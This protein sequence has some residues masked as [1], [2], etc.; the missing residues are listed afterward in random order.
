MLVQAC[1][2]TPH[3]A[4]LGQLLVGIAYSATC[5]AYCSSVLLRRRDL[6]RPVYGHTHTAAIFA[7]LSSYIHACSGV[8]IA[9]ITIFDYRAPPHCLQACPRTFMY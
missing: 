1:L 6:G 4:F 9:I 5:E 7:G 2:S 8:S 3:L